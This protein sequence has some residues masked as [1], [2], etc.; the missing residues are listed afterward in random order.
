MNS[1]PATVLPLQNKPAAAATE[2]GRRTRAALM[3]A[4]LDLMQ[5][6]RGYGTISIREV[7]KQAGIVPTAFYRHFKD[8]D[9]LGLAMVDD[10]GRNLRQRLSEIRLTGTSAKDMILHSINVFQKYVAEHPKYF[11]VLSGERHGGSPI[12]RQAIRNEVDQFIRDM[13]KDVH[14]RE[15]LPQLSLANLRNVC[16][17][18]V[19][20]MISASTEFLDLQ[21]Y[22]EEL[23]AR[24]NSYV[25]QLRIIF[26]GAHGWRERG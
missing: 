22:P 4:A 5:T 7:T 1:K 8:M 24:I 16:E 13:A 18:V 9:E 10:C 15:L 14:D 23:Q 17:L 20:T 12:I 21:G 26:A 3:N 6:G 19:S 11:L 25:H 2:R